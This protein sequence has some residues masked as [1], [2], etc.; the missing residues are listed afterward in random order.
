MFIATLHF[1]AKTVAKEKERKERKKKR[2]MNEP[3]LMKMRNRI[4][5]QRETIH[6]KILVIISPPVHN[7]TVKKKD[8]PI[9]RE[10]V[11]YF[12]RNPALE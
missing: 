3:A 8:S 9:S 11:I 4:S 2:K 12:F 6:F 10:K 7:V 1:H 5:F